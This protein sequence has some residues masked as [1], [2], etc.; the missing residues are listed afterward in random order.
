MSRPR[1]STPA[2]AVAPIV[3]TTT[4]PEVAALPHTASVDVALNWD[5]Q[6]ATSCAFDLF[7]DP[8]TLGQIASGAW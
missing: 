5:E 7:P 8:G 6:V 1:A 4:D 3:R 2:V